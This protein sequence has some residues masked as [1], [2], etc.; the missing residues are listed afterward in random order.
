M[1]NM[2]APQHTRFRAYVNAAFSVRRVKA[3]EDSIRSTTRAILD[4][5]GEDGTCD[6]AKDVAD[7]LPTAVTCDLLGIAR[8][9]RPEIARLS[10]SAVPLGDPEFGGRD[11]RSAR[12]TS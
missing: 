11:A 9:D 4:A 12:S 8:A 2:D 10:R 5:V 6:F 1:L 7:A 3:L